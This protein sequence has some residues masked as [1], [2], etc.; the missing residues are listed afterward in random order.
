MGCS[1]F[2]LQEMLSAPARRLCWTARVWIQS[3]FVCP[4]ANLLFVAKK[5]GLMTGRY[6]V[7]LFMRVI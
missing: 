1:F 5:A 7:P 2:F 6:S 3:S 4:F